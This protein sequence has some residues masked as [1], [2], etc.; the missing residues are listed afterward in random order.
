MADVAEVPTHSSA[1]TR[2]V[3]HL[4]ASQG[5]DTD[6]LLRAA[7]ID[8]ERLKHA[9]ER[10]TMREVDRMWDLAVG[11]TGQATLGLDRTIAR[12]HID[13]NIAA[14]AMWS[15][16]DLAS[17]LA[18]LQKY[19]HL[20]NDAHAFTLVADRGDRWLV[21]DHGGDGLSPRQREE[22]SMFGTLLLLQTVTHHQLRP[23]VVEFVFPEPASLH[24][25]RMAFH[26][27][28]RFGQDANRMKL[29]R[30]DLALRVMGAGESLFAIQEQVIEDRLERY[31]RART[32]YRASEEIIRRLHLGEPRREDLARSLGLADS[33]FERRLK[34]EGQSFDDLL[35]GVRRELAEHYLHQEGYTPTRVANLLG[36]ETP[37]QLAAACK[38]WFGVATAQYRNQAQ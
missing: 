16:P 10:F 3:V 19:L 32:S 4:F 25:Y 5:V 17:G 27:P 11:R 18:V 26:C 36:W 14:Q 15:S 7:N 13:F 30:D 21:H 6:W 28:L 35:D 23:L 2:G 29:S 37:T 34:S 20:I 31:G 22:F 33:A 9:H 12:R 38:R 8:P 1:W 24:P